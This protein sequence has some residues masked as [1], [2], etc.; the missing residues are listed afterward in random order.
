[1]PIFFYGATAIK[2]V[3][4]Y[5]SGFF[6]VWPYLLGLVIYATVLYLLNMRALG[7][8]RGH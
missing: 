3:I 5:G 2:E 7:K 4:V 6:G 1:M 8:Y